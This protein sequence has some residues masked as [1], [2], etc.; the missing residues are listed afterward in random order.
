MKKAKVYDIDDLWVDRFVDERKDD[1]EFKDQVADGGDMVDYMGWLN[2]QLY[3]SLA[4]NCEG[5]PKEQI[6][7]LEDRDWNGFIGWNKV[8]TDGVGM[9][10]AKLQGLSQRVNQPKK[11]GKIEDVLSALE[12]HEREV[13]GVY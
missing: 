5:L 10:G 4:L 1:K 3:N 6:E 12:I 13:K 7:N 9:N 11:V 8:V 2:T